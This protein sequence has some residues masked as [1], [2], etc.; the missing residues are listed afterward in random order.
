MAQGRRVPLVEFLSQV[1]DPRCAVWE[2]A[3]SVGQCGDVGRFVRRW[4][5]SISFASLRAGARSGG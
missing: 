3:S 4:P 1:P 2:L 5:G